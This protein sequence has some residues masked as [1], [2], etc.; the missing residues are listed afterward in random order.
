MVQMCLPHLR[1]LVKSTES[2]FKVVSGIM[3]R[4]DY[5]ELLQVRIMALPTF[6][7]INITKCNNLHK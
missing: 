2:L 1:S 5:G 6:L 3:A 4:K 7:K